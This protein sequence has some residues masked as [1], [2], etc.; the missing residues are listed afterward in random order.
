MCTCILLQ[1]KKTEAMASVKERIREEGVS[2]HGEISVANRE[3]LGSSK[4][5]KADCTLPISDR[6]D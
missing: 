1:A 2:V 3:A 5:F 4:G 6:C